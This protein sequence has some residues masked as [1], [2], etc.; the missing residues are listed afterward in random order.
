MTTTEQKMAAVVLV[1][2]S[3][4]NLQAII[5]ATQHGGLNI[6]IK[7][8]I[9]NRPGVKGL[10]RAADA[11]IPTETLDHKKFAS[12]PEFDH[13]LQQHIDRHQP[14]LL[15]LAGFMRILTTEFV[16]HYQGRLLNIHPSLLPKHTG[17]NTH[18]RAIEAQ[19]SEHGA[20]I[21]F[22]TE[23]L[24]GGP[25][26]LQ[27]RVPVKTTDTPAQLAE[28]VLQVE[29]QIYP[30]AIQWFAEGRIQLVGN[31]ILF[32]QKQLQSPLSLTMKENREQ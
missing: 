9:S 1:S 27:G 21:H 29:H 26:I 6:E 16:R 10:Q 19:D 4:S 30:Q 31:H 28:R 3:G 5:D 14:K 12:R 2:G 15:I 8:V 20:S 24:D 23:E 18:Q 22:V 13:A 32:D 25:V 17:L 7:A 11:G